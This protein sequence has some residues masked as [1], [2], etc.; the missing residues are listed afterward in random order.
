M[1][2]VKTW[3]TEEQTQISEG[4]KELENFLDKNQIKLNLPKEIY[5]IKSTCN[6]EFGAEGYTRRNFIVLNNAQ[7]RITEG[8]IAHELF[9][10]Y[11]RY[12]K[13]MRDKLYQ[14]IGFLPCNPINYASAVNNQAITNPDCPV[15][16]HYTTLEGQDV[17][18]A[19]YSPNPYKGENMLQENADI[20]LIVLT[21][22]DQNKKPLIK[23]GKAVMYGPEKM[24]AL[25]EKTGGNTQYILHPEEVCAEH[26]AMLVT[27]KKVP[28]PKYL[29]E[30][31]II[32]QKK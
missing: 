19:L 29:E 4:L 8:L 3:N 7:E 23:E 26:F 27:D 2:E 21:G 12:N 30:M 22:D 11:S 32:L 10:V 15:V 1:K 9:H 5:I 14:V 31:K 28:E 13:D 25:F 24:A 17:M 18:L 20:G 6:E 16:A